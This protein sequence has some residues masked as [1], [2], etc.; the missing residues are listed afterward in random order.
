MAGAQCTYGNITDTMSL[1]R[2]L[3]AHGQTLKL[4]ATPRIATISSRAVRRHWT[5]IFF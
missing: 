2:Y 4:I 5:H 3:T 1:I